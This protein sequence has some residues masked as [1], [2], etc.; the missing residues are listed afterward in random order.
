MSNKNLI[1]LLSL[2]RSGSTLT[3]KIIGAHENVYTRSE[4][5]IMLHPLFSLKKEGINAKYNKALEYTAT[6][7]FIH[8]LPGG[9][10]SYIKYLQDMYGS[11]YDDYLTVNKK[12]IFLDKTPRYYLIMDELKEVFPN[13]KFILL[14]RNPLAVLS[15]IINTWAKNNISILFDLKVDLI[16]GLDIIV[17]RIS[18][19][20]NDLYILRYET[21]LMNPTETLKECFDYLDLNFDPS[22]MSNYA[23]NTDEKWLFGD[24]E[25]VYQKKGIDSTNDLKWIESL[26]DPQHWRLINDYLNHIGK[27]RF[28]ILGYSFE[29]FKKI[30]VDKMPLKD[31]ELINKNTFSLDTLLESPEEKQNRLLRENIQK[32]KQSR[33]YKLGQAIVK[34]YWSIKDIV[35]EKK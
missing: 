13:A 9:R 27:D 12:T 11:M 4:P 31:I 20:P 1:F 17:D 32:I 26:A 24:P 34:P 19:D 30:I 7:D 8:N 35:T 29:A 33:S 23:G 14:V 16:D 10:N 6:R 5:W 2:P 15:S 28:E 21:M 3:Q 22:V 25:N 18:K